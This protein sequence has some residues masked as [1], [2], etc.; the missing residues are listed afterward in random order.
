DSSA[1]LGAGTWMA[2][3]PRLWHA[4]R[5]FVPKGLDRSDSCR[6]KR[7]DRTGEE[8]GKTHNEGRSGVAD[9]VG[10]A[11]AVEERAEEAGEEEGA[12]DARD[13]AG[14]GENRPLAEDHA[15]N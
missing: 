14:S 12:G 7:G 4:G 11:D 9:G 8:Y 13:A 1:T 3:I 10:G 2:R 15:E 6:T 5:L